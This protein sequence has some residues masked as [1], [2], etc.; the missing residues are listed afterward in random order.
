MQKLN[1]FHIVLKSPK[2]LKKKRKTITDTEN[3]IGYQ[4]IAGHKKTLLQ[5]LESTI[6]LLLRIEI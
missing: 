5:L 3:T 2:R 1:P 4:K 6:F